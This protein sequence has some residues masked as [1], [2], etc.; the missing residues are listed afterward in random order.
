M[1]TN[2]L[3]ILWFFLLM[4]GL[5]LTACSAAAPSAKAP[6]SFTDPFAY[7]AAVGTID[8][9]DVRYTGPQVPDAIISGFKKAAGLEAST[10]P[11]D[12]FKKATIWRCMA[13]KV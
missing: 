4:T 9:P 7:C 12:V 2:R 3:H 10:E 13:S 11:S 5:L 8:K 6:V 1:K